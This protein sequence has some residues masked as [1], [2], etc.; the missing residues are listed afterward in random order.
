MRAIC[1]GHVNWDVT[2]RVDRLPATDGEA[3]IRERAVGGGGSA[4]NVA[5]GLA[6][7]DVSTA[8]V[9][10]VGGDD[11]GRSAREEL[12]RANVD[13]THVHTVEGETAVKYL[14]VDDDGEVMVLGGPGVNEAFEADDLPPEA[15]SAADH[16][17][18]TSQRPAT[19]AE[20]AAR[21]TRAGLTVSFDPGRRVAERSYAG[22]LRRA[23]LLFLNER[24][25]DAVV[26]VPLTEQTLVLK[27]GARG[28]EVRTPQRTYSHPGYD[29][30]VVDTSGA[31]DAFAAGFLAARLDGRDFTRC[32]AVAN[33]CGALAAEIRGARA[34]FSWGDVSALVG[35]V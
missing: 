33:A 14:V 28:A 8:L 7:L 3:T 31:G 6:G 17:H 20:L 12:T 18:L 19:A 23:D 35:G 22:T 21:A 27:R 30:D 13:C 25:A 1:A 4:A 34:R 16:L 26:D 9:G 5:A 2:L 32:L 11:H 15:M 29:V 24:E 10:S